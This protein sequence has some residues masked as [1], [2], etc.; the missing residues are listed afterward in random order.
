LF[1]CIKQ[2]KYV[3]DAGRPT[4]KCERS[5][6]NKYINKGINSAKRKVFAT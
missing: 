6:N 5:R 4:Q 2:K 3:Y 1:I